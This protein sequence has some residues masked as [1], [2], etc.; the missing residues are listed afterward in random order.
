M[1]DRVLLSSFDHSYLQLARRLSPRI[2]TGVLT[3]LAIRQP[4]NYL[5]R[6]RAQAYN[7]RSSAVRARMVQALRSSGHE[8]YVW[9]VNDERTM[10]KLIKMGVSGI[11]TDYPQTLHR[12]LAQR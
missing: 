11:I 7:P 2:R 5:E 6:I 12:L 1:V 8:V 10:R 3:M 4:M 9:T